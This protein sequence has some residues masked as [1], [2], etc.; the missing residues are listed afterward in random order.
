VWA[1]KRYR[2]VL[3][4]EPD[5]ATLSAMLKAL[6]RAGHQATGAATFEEARRQMALDT[7]DVLVSEARLGAYSGLH[8][9]FLGLV[10]RPYFHGV[11]VGQEADAALERD[12]I[13]AGG[14]FLVRPLAA[15]R[16]VSIIEALT[17]NDLPTR[18]EPQFDRR[19]AQRRQAT[20]PVFA[21]ERRVAD[22]RRRPSG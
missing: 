9:A 4:V 16:L 1:D 3:V 18:I 11:I 15:D 2:L 21:A 10:N 8:L 19:V 13:Q 7:P 22:R 17:A 20:L 5:A 12:V 6:R 14:A